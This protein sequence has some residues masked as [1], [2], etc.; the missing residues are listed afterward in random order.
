MIIVLTNLTMGDNYETRLLPGVR[1]SSIMGILK[2]VVEQK[3]LNKT[4]VLLFVLFGVGAISF[5][6]LLFGYYE[7]ENNANNLYE[8][9]K[10]HFEIE[11]LKVDIE[12]LW[13]KIENSTKAENTIRKKR[14]AGQRREIDGIVVTGPPVG[15]RSRQRQLQ[16]SPIAYARFTAPPMFSRQ[17]ET[18]PMVSSESNRSGEV[19]YRFW[20]LDEHIDPKMFRTYFH[21]NPGSG[22]VNIRQGGWYTVNVQFVYHDLSGFWSYGIFVGDIAK[23][24][25]Y[26]TEQL[27]DLTQYDPVSHKVF[28]QCHVSALLYIRELETVSIRCMYGARK[29]L[30]QPEFTFWDIQLVQLAPS[31]Q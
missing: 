3:H 31:R 9:T 22:S 27:R 1:E 20:K 6:V 30:T 8:M 14:N 29:I 4:F 28:K 21:M 12:N 26:T 19:T 2:H 23:A 15:R 13:N 16:Q 10:L 25:C 7:C 11:S 18:G 5:P 17:Y 24:K